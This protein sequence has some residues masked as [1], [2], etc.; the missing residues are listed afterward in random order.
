MVAG[1]GVKILEPVQQMA[2]TE[3][4]CS[5]F[6]A[7]PLL[8]VRDVEVAGASCVPVQNELVVGCDENASLRRQ[9]YWLSDNIQRLLVWSAMNDPSRRAARP[10][11]QPKETLASLSGAFVIYHR[12]F[13]VQHHF[14]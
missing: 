5:S 13:T 4:Q 8:C 10:H 12:C 11:S 2:L 1:S 7:E 6:H 14:I 9:V 3:R